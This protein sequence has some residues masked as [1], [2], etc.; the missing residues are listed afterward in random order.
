MKNLKAIVTSY[1]QT[2][3]IVIVGIA[4]ATS[5][6]YH[7]SNAQCVQELHSPANCINIQ[8][9]LAPTTCPDCEPYVIDVPN[10]GWLDK[11]RCQAGYTLLDCSEWSEL[12]I[13]NSYQW[14]NSNCEIDSCGSAQNNA[15]FN[16][17]CDMA[18]GSSCS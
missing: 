16:I 10:N 4:I 18:A 5:I 9:A 3:T 15:T 7:E 2:T 11:Q 8:G 14:I 13:M 17:T 12:F 6:G 1:L